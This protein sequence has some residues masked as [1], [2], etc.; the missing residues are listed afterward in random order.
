LATNLEE[1]LIPT[2]EAEKLN[3]N[4]Q[5]IVNTVETIYK[6]ILLQFNDFNFEK[7][8]SSKL[9]ELMKAVKH[10]LFQKGDNNDPSLRCLAL[11]AS[12]RANFK[13]FSELG[14]EF[15]GDIAV[16]HSEIGEFDANTVSEAY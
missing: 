8:E 7:Q 3:E 4:A 13:G 12:N 16:T 14:T 5:E 11:F 15:E 6:S 2:L 10:A 1:L 9:T